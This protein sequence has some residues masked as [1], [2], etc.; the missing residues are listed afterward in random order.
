MVVA[1]KNAHRL[2]QKGAGNRDA[3]T[4]LNAHTETDTDMGTETDESSELP[5]LASNLTSPVSST[6]SKASRDVIGRGWALQSP[7]RVK[8]G[9]YDASTE[10][11]RDI[12]GL[13]SRKRMRVD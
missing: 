3:F 13:G 7:T 8:K 1:R 4:K 11:G 6:G 12:W 2:T 10:K 9:R 5:S